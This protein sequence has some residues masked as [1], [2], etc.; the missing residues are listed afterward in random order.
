MSWRSRIA[1]ALLLGTITSVVFAWIVALFPLDDWLDISAPI[2]AGFDVV[3]TAQ[4]GSGWL[5]NGDGV[6]SPFS[7]TFQFS[8]CQ[9]GSTAQARS[10]LSFTP[11]WKLL[12]YVDRSVL[13]SIP[14]IPDERLEIHRHGWPW[15]ALEWRKHVPGRIGTGTL[16]TTS[17][18]ATIEGAFA[19]PLSWTP[20]GSPGVLPLIVHWPP[21][22]ANTAVFGVI[23]MAL[24]LLP[25]I[26]RTCEWWFKRRCPICGYDRRGIA[27]GAP[28]PECGS[29][30]LS[31]PRSRDATRK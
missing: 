4:D 17:S 22:L 11:G 16:T 18:A 3:E 30:A 7:K 10:W 28:C 24:L 19:L 25:R 2:G 6:A 31:R 21:L 26:G 8:F 1:L 27:A 29:V 14:R 20:R 23:W 15:Q 5:V 13:E 12:D 9:V